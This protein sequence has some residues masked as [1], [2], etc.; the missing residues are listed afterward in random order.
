MQNKES[1]KG[2]E[3]PELGS[4]E[5]GLPDKTSSSPR[6]SD[7]WKS[8]RTKEEIRE[9]EES[10]ER[11]KEEQ[12]R[13]SRAEAEQIRRSSPTLKEKARQAA[14]AFLTFLKRKWYNITH[15]PIYSKTIEHDEWMLVRAETGYIIYS[16]EF[17]HL[18]N[19]QV[20]I[21]S[22]AAQTDYI[23]DPNGYG[24]LL[25]RRGLPIGIG[26]KFKVKVEIR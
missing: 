24:H 23:T 2:E 13:A 14:Q 11:W 21:K 3:T 17:G 15:R 7:S 16:H 9:I 10:L 12:K 1:K 19:P 22:P 20:I 5:G 6:G 25:I 26:S 8:G 4:S 18:K